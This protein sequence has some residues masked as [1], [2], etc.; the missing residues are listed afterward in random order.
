M[1]ALVP[2]DKNGV[3][4]FPS[5]ATVDEIRNSLVP[6]KSPEI[7]KYIAMIFSALKSSDRGDVDAVMTSEMYA[8]ALSE[9]PS[10]AIQAGVRNF[11][12]GE[13]ENASRTFVPSTAELV[14]E[15]RKQMW[16]RI[17]KE[18]PYENPEVVLPDNHFSKKWAALKDDVL[19][20]NV[21][22]D[23]LNEGGK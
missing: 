18:Q 8:M 17:R 19:S 20:A 6:A 22:S 10:W 1:G 21:V 15:V 11:I 23:E 12:M 9:F 13:V 2:I 7:D 3:L 16:L 4:Y 5:D 14:A